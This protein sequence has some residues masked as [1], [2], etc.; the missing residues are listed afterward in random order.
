V[1]REPALLL[2]PRLWAEEGFIFYAFA[3]HHSL[4][5]I[6]TTV[7]VGYLTLFNSLV[8]ALQA[9]AFSVEKAATVS[10]YLGFTIQLIPVYIITY[11]KHEFWDNAFKKIICVIIVIVFTAPELWLN[12]TNSHFIFGLSTFLIM[13]VAGKQLSGRQNYFFGILLFMGGLTGPASIF[14]TPLF[15]LKA[16]R[17]KSKEKS[18]QA[19]IISVCSIIQSGVILYS[20]LYN[21]AYNRLSATNYKRTIYHFFSDNFSL[22]PHTSTSY[23]Q[24]SKFYFGLGFG[25]LMALYCIYLLIKTKKNTDYLISLI[26]LLVVGTFSTLGSLN[27]AGSPRY[28]Y[29]PGCIFM[30]VITNEAFKIKRAKTVMNYWAAGVLLFCLTTNLFYYRHGMANVYDTNYP[31]WPNEVTKWRADNTYKPKVQPG[32]PGQCVQL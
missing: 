18:I 16:Y 21:N 4:F 9:K 7:H 27:M 14:F 11:T 17:E 31:Q 2:H 22:L 10:T 29:I 26:S 20:I 5:D 32:T 30:L 25:V 3:F 15:L 23:L 19:V 24:Q 1:A 13:L 6:F 12:T 28:A 8:S